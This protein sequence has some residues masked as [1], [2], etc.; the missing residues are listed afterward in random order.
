MR[1]QKE[2][3]IFQCGDKVLIKGE[4]HLIEKY[5]RPEFEVEHFEYATNKGAWFDHNEITLIEKTN[6]K[7]RRRLIKELDEEE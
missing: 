4:I 1:K 2:E 6:R 5:L 7:L 3:R